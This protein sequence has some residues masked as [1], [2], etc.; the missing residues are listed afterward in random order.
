LGPV[1][2]VRGR[3]PR[4]PPPSSEGRSPERF[5]THVLDKSKQR[6]KPHKVPFRN[7][8]R[9]KALKKPF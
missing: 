4:S 5:H 3:Q 8:S 7:P 9:I 2:R 6:Y 1:F